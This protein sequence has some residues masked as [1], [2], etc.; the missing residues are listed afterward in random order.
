MEMGGAPNICP[1]KCAP[2]LGRGGV[3]LGHQWQ[4]VHGDGAV[5]ATVVHPFLCH[6]LPPASPLRPWISMKLRA[7]TYPWTTSLRGEC[8][9]RAHAACTFLAAVLA[10]SSK[11]NNS[12]Q[13]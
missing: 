10:I 12:E 1:S 3:G 9:P 8:L 6:K 7:F 5:T 2:A 13:T 11:Y 4:N